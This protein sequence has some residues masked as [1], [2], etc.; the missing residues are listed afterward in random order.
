MNRHERRKMEAMKPS[1]IQQPQN[2]RPARVAIVVPSTDTIKADTSM[3]IA[4][5]AAYSLMRG[6]MV[7]YQNHQGS[8]ITHSRNS[9]VMSMLKH[10]P[11]YLMWFDSDM[12]C[13][14]DTLMRLLAHNK[15]IVGACYTK[16][17][18]PYNMLGNAK[19]PGRDLS[20]AHGLEPML[21]MPG[22][23]IL[24]KM[25]VYKAIPWP[26]YFESQFRQNHETPG[27]APVST[28]EAFLQTL[29]DYWTKPLPPALRTRLQDDAELM[30]WA[31]ETAVL[32]S[33][34]LSE[35][36]GEDFN[37]SKKA[38]SHGFEL[39]CDLDLTMQ[40]G[41]IGQNISF[42]KRPE[43]KADAVKSEATANG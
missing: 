26:W 27:A 35:A 12:V 14:P 8:M 37:W 31:R 10:N 15:D 29:D 1:A 3:H 40:I 32:E 41:H 19:F 38:R 6:V 24:V 2:L 42:A 4:G 43:P 39:W 22:G 21:H 20:D 30:E 33:Q 28:E 23:M 16:R 13:P 36:M 5:M 18:P 9:L 7:W 25:S 11:D 17:V 34:I